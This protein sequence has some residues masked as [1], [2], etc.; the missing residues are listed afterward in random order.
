LEPSRSVTFSTP[1]VGKL[2]FVSY[3]PPLKME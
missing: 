1:L 2:P 3:Q